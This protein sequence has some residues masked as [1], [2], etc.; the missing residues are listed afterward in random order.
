MGLDEDGFFRVGPLS[1][2]LHEW[3]AL[4]SVAVFVASLVA[5]EP[6]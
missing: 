6:T 2:L 1:L 3:L 4:V 5:G